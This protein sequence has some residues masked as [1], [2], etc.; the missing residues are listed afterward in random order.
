MEQLHT[1]TPLPVESNAAI[2]HVTFDGC[3]YFCTM[4]CKCEI[5]RLSPC[6]HVW[7]KYTTRKEYDCICYDYGA[8]CFWASS[9]GCSQL[10]KLDCCMNEID[11]ISVRAYSEYGMITGISYQDCKNALLVSFPHAVVEVQKCSEE[12][13]IIYTTQDACVLDVL[14][15]CPGMLVMC[16]KG[17]RY[18][19]E[20]IDHHG[21]QVNCYCLPSSV[22][23]KNLIFNPCACKH[24]P[25]EVFLLKKGCYPYLGKCDIPL[26]CLSLVPCCCNFKICDSCCRDDE[27]YTNEMLCRDILESIALTQAALSH[28]LN[29]EGEKLQK[30]LCATNDVDQILRVNHEV[31]QTL[32]NITQ[33]EHTLYTAMNA[34]TEHGVCNFS[35]G[36]ACGR[37]TT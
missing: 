29:A 31:N 32:V 15:I 7:R 34:L 8:R 21:E 12:A 27:C 10:F 14:S 18:H 33:L 3:D 6:R 36:H 24:T 9:K 11:C 2:N 37:S 30:I 25:I 35:A 19:I 26:S 22:L 13:K 4:R 28:I 5:I 1:L 23:P 16:S 17:G 20:A